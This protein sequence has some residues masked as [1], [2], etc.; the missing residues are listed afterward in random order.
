MEALKHKKTFFF[1]IFF[2]VFTVSTINSYYKN[3][4]KGE[5]IA[6]NIL[7]VL[8]ENC[9]CK[10]IAQSTYSLG[11]QYSLNGGF[12]V[13]RATY[14]LTDCNYTNFKDEVARIDKILKNKVKGI[15]D[16]DL[17]DLDFISDKEHKT[18]TLTNTK[19]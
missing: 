12:T 6:V 10:E 8:K 2:A 3:S 4:E 9:D 11:K 7:E 14:S 15:K 19:K 18:A 13:E 16:F 17:I 5:K 1:S